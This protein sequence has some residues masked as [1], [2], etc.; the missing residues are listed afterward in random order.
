M[1]NIGAIRNTSNPA[2][3]LIK[4]QQSVDF[5]I[6][7]VGK[8]IEILRS[9][10]YSNPI[11]TMVQEYLANARDA[12]RETDNPKIIVTLPTEESPTLSIRDFGP[13]IDQD[14]MLNYFVLYGNS[15]KGETNSQAGGF[16][17]GSKLAWAYTDAFSIVT[18]VKGTCTHY[19]AHITKNSN[20]TLELVSQSATKESDGT[21]IKIPVQP[22][23]F[24]S[25]REAVERAILFWKVEEKPEIVGHV[26]KDLSPIQLCAGVEVYPK[27]DV[28]DLFE[29]NHYGSMVV[30]ID[31]TP[32]ELSKS[33]ISDNSGLEKLYENLAKNSALVFHVGNG[34]VEV[35]ASRESI[36]E[37]ERTAK[38]LLNKVESALK[39]MKQ[40]RKE[41][42]ESEGT[43]LERV[44][45][46]K[47]LREYLNDSEMQVK[48]G[49]DTLVVSCNSNWYSD[50]DEKYSVSSPELNKLEIDTFKVDG[51]KGFKADRK[52]RRWN[53]GISLSRLLIVADTPLSKA[54]ETM[55]IKFAMGAHGYNKVALLNKGTQTEKYL[56]SLVEKFGAIKL[57]E[58]EL[59]KV[60]RKQAEKLPEGSLKILKLVETGY[61]SRKS[62]CEMTLDLET[63]AGKWIY[64]TRD[65]ADK[66]EISQY[67][68]L[69]EFLKGCGYNIGIVGTRA[70][71]TLKGLKDFTPL[72]DF[73]SEPTK[74]VTKK[75]WDKVLDL[76]CHEFS[77]EVMGI[78]DEFSWAEYKLLKDSKLAK[79]LAMLN[80][81][82][83]LSSY[84][85][86]LSVGRYNG[87]P[88]FLTAHV[89]KTDKRVSKIKEL[90]E[91]FPKYL[92]EKY[93]LLSSIGSLYNFQ[94][95]DDDKR[96]TKRTKA[97]YTSQLIG[98]LNGVNGMRGKK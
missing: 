75:Q 47:K 59:P 85:Y 48:D 2:V 97:V 32:Y 62:T 43:F 17:L 42:L 50:N 28:G 72:A 31:G 56:L 4:S 39:G 29:K 44:E 78:L 88:D 11:Q 5:K 8:I 18:Y 41:M 14:R 90:A 25:I 95:R 71:E 54:K 20:G 19:L 84:G 26:V 89:L 91:S 86:E 23:D 65:N 87:T 81:Y 70:A 22:H 45:S 68:S 69:R 34:V 9:K 16:G 83:G 80:L 73:L 21:E 13:G 96:K 74:F 77:C 36:S 27:G 6:G 67:G 61:K 52:S 51:Y 55:A 60:E 63:N 37:N 92:E 33:F 1:K 79:E 57:S 7:D 64:F 30:A 53:K 94:G 76:I 10:I 93:P 24:E 49:K 38:V 58:I 46:F 3:N 12:G 66:F 40:Y 98:F 15:T 35:A 82:N